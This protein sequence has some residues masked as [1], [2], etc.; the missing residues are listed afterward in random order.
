MR[1]RSWLTSALVLGACASGAEPPG[2]VC[3]DPPRGPRL[4]RFGDV[5]AWSGVD[6]RYVNVGFQGGGLA[7]ADLDGDGRPEIVAGRRGGGLALYRNLGSLRFADAT[8]AAGLDPATAATAIAAAD[9]DNDGARELVIAHAGETLVMANLGDGRFREAARLTDAGT[10][11][12]VLPV[13]LDGDGLLDLYLGNY[14]KT[15]AARSQNRLYLNQG[16]LGWMFASGLGDGLTWTTSAFD[17]DGDGD[18]DLYVAHDTLLVDFGRPGSSGTSLWPGDLLLRND[19]VG[20]DRVPRFTDLAGAVGLARPRSSMG[21]LLA[22]FNGDGQLDLYVTDFGA[23]KLFLREPG[24]GFVERAAQ[25]GVDVVA[26]DNPYCGEGSTSRDCLVLSW[27]AAL[28]DLDLDG[29][30]DLL[31]V[32]GE[33]SPGNS[34]PVLVLSQGA[35][36][37]FHEL[38]PDIPCMDGRALIVTDLDGDGDQDVVIGQRDGRLLIYENV[39][40]PDPHA[41]LDVTLRGRRSNRD[42]AGAVVTIHQASGRVQ[43]RP[44]G[45]GGVVHATGP[46]EAFFGLGD[47]EVV[48]VVVQWPSG[49]RSTR[50]WPGAGRLV[51]EEEP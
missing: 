51:I 48:E 35:D 37:V 21:G 25:L 11:E 3:V 44:V 49:R 38:T 24:G 14:D 22:D 17:F 8:V 2:P 36:G 5:T 20:P 41:W 6:F 26:R 19:G 12:H 33:T 18:L 10:T 1:P 9:L 47:D 42:G 13:D 45:A 32:N 50:A 40:R 27:S 46:A 4:V 34:P 7:V 15:N 31:I 39:G 16:G 28:T 30:D 23:K 43:A 29:H